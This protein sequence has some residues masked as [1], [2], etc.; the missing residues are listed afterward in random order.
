MSEQQSEPA[1]GAVKQPDGTPGSENSPQDGAA[2]RMSTGDENTSITRSMPGESTP[3]AANQGDAEPVPSAPEE[4]PQS[5]G[6]SG[7]AAIG[8][9]AQQ[10]A[11]A[12]D[13]SRASGEHGSGPRDMLTDASEG[14]DHMDAAMTPDGPPAVG[15]TGVP[16]PAGPGTPTAYAAQETPGNPSGVPVPSVHAAAGTS[17]ESAEPDGVRIT[18]VTGP[19]KP[20][21]EVDTRA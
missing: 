3:P 2:D 20:D 12:G 15:G 13:S 17:E 5:S 1:A 7:G 11:A 19:G 14:A 21:G 9:Q 10:A 6:G 4:S 16:T 18:S 8:T